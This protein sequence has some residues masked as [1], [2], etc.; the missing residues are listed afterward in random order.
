MEKAGEAYG[1]PTLF[2]GIL[3]TVK[4]ASDMGK[5]V[6]MS[7]TPYPNPATQDIHR[8]YL[9]TYLLCDKPG[10]T[11]SYTPWVPFRGWDG[12]NAQAI[13]NPAIPWESEWDLDFGTP[14]T[15]AQY[16]HP[17]TVAWRSYSKCIVIVNPN[18]TYQQFPLG[19]R[20]RLWH[21]TSGTLIDMTN[22]GPG[23]IMN[24]PPN[25]GWVLF[26]A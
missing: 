11:F 14:L 5:R 6:M 16:A 9:G 13:G 23:Y 4:Q 10:I 3:D 25:T 8:F 21:P 24:V 15:D 20:Y 1:D 17:I 18:Q 2:A 7:M 26:Y 19:G 12:T 22:A